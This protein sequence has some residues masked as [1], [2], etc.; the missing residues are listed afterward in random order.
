MVLQALSA[1]LALKAGTL[2]VYH[3]N[4]QQIFREQQGSSSAAPTAV[5]VNLTLANPSARVRCHSSPQVCLGVVLVSTLYSRE[6]VV[7]CFANHFADALNCPAKLG[8]PI[9]AAHKSTPYISCSQ[10]LDRDRDVQGC[11]LVTQ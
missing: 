6:E 2:P 5:C 11:T 9:Y 1:E 3:N 7:N 8:Q 10:G 4:L